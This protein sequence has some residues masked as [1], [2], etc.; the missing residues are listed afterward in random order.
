MLTNLVTENTIL[1][2]FQK[3]N[4]CSISISQRVVKAWIIA[5]V[6]NLASLILKK[7]FSLILVSKNASEI[8]LFP[9]KE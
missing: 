3:L 4:I 7:S 2:K 6:F 8:C 9:E 1:L 5:N